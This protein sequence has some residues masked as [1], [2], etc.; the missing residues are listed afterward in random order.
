MVKSKTTITFCKSI[1]DIFGLK[2]NNNTKIKTMHKLKKAAIIY[3][4]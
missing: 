4:K 2:N 1:K 3:L